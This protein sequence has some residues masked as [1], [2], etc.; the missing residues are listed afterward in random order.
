MYIGLLIKPNLQS[1]PYS[2]PTTLTVFSTLQ[3]EWVF[4]NINLIELLL[5]NIL[6]LSIALR[7]R[8]K[9]LNI[10]RH[11][12]F[13]LCLNLQLVYVCCAQSCLT[14]CDPMNCSLPGFY[15]HRTSQARILEW[16][17]PSLGDRLNQGFEP[18]SPVY[19]CCIVRWIL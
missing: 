15:V 14:L 2:V 16:P 1:S 4:W 12:R 5:L 3:L 19:I 8:T 13:V 6:K 7:I 11:V 9:I 17:F 10:A 18:R